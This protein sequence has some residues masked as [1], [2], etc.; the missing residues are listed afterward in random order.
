MSQYVEYQL[1]MSYIQD[2]SWGV[3]QTSWVHYGSDF[4]SPIG[5]GPIQKV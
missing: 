2:D 5:M 3:W 1:V 4:E